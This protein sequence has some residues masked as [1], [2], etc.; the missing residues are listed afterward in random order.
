MASATVARLPSGNRF[1]VRTSSADVPVDVSGGRRC[2]VSGVVG[3]GSWTAVKSRKPGRKREAHG[4]LL[5]GRYA[6]GEAIGQGR[7]T[8]YRG[9]D[10]RLRRRIAVKQVRLDAG[11]E[12]AGDTRRGP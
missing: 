6:L 10:L 2:V 12:P 1:G 5:V 7:S 9:K 3:P 8:V 4:D 11:P